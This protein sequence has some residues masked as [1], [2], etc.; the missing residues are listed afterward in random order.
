VQAPT[1]APSS[2][3]PTGTGYVAPFTLVS[4]SQY[5]CAVISGGGAPGSCITDGPGDYTNAESCTFRVNQGVHLVVLQYDVEQGYDYISVG[6]TFY[7]TATI[8]DGVVAYLGDTITW[9]ADN[10]YTDGFLVCAN[11]T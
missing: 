5:G 11:A 2:A 7:Y 1:L 8:L 3:A 10:W 9:T 6:G 4:G